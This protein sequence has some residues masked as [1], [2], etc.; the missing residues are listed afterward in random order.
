MPPIDNTVTPALVAHARLLTTLLPATDDLL[1]S[2][3][4]APVNRQLETLRAMTLKRK[5][6]AELLAKRIRYVLFAISLLLAGALAYLITR[7]RWRAQFLRRRANF[8]HAIAT[9]S[10]H[11]I[12][13]R[14][15]EAAAHVQA[16]FAE[17]A[18]A[19][20]AERAYFVMAADE[21]RVYQWCLSEAHLRPGWPEQALAIACGLEDDAIQ[22]H[23]VGKLPSGDVRD[24]LRAAGLHSWLCIVSRRGRHP[25][26]L[27]F[28]A[29]R[30]GAIRCTSASSLL[31]MALDAIAHTLD[32][33]F[34]EQDRQ[35]L[36]AH[37]QQARGMETIG[38]L[39]S[40]IAH[41]FNNIVGAILGYTE[42][43]QAHVTADGRSPRTWV[44]SVAPASAP[45]T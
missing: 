3:L 34:L 35:R 16:A 27:G 28:D 4:A 36:E 5:S 33:E 9:L 17:L 11:L 38:A 31:R 2:L 45:V 8:E 15:H 6:S 20:G 12:N 26:V 10:T 30:P 19:L 40:G 21:P 24:A 29:L 43:A 1:R 32:R 14:P 25:C 23:D 37:L 7:L 39:S 41:N 44:K 22:I 13:T 18:T 42:T